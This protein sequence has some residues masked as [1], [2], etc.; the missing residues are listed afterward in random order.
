MQAIIINNK[1]I[2]DNYYKLTLNCAD[3]AHTACPG[4]FVM[5]KVN[6]GYDPLLR[7]PFGIHSVNQN[8]IEILY[9]VVGQGTKLMSRLVPKEFIDVF[10]PLG[11]GFVIDKDIKQALLIAGGVGVAPML[12]LAQQLRNRNTDIR[13]FLGGKNKADLLALDD[14]TRLGVS[15]HLATED[16][17]YGTKGLITDLLADYLNLQRNSLTLPSPQ[18]GE[19]AIS[20]C[21]MA[22]FACGPKAMLAHV[23]SLAK[24]ADLV[25]QVSLDTAMA[26]GVGACGGCVVKVKNAAA[27]DGFVY[28]RV[29]KD[30]PVFT[31]DKIIW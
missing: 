3:I 22:V 16:G 6:N 21:D 30:G 27:S 4:Q 8:N 13:L 2:T 31:A 26:C 5:L 10:G 7:R 24:S 14:F 17:S 29:C 18:R 23:S 1:K 11:N 15:L 28:A 20:I 19:E 25:C 12:Y 9:Q